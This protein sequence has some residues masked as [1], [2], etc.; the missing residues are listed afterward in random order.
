MGRAVMAASPAGRRR[1][2]VLSEVRFAVNFPDLRVRGDL[3]T[4]AP[5]DVVDDGT[6]GRRPTAPGPRID[7]LVSGGGAASCSPSPSASPAWPSACLR[8]PQDRP[9]I[10]LRP[11]I[12]VYALDVIG[13]SLAAVA[14]QRLRAARVRR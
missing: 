7:Q 6:A 8:W 9:G 3:S 1:Y 5:A 2:C 11:T 14:A 13:L 12:I 4:V 10:G